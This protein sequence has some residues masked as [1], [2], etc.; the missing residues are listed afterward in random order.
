MGK[1]GA[2]G[3]PAPLGGVEPH[4]GLLKVP[5]ADQ[6]LYKIMTAE[7]LLQ[8]IDNRYL[9]FNRVDHYVDFPGADP[10]DGAQLPG[11]VSG[12]EAAR[13]AKVPVFSV[14]NYYDQARARTYACCFSLE[15]S[16]HIWTNYANGSLKGKV[17]IVFRY[18]PL[19]QLLNETFASD[20]SAL[21]YNSMQ[22]RQ[23]FSINYGL[24]E[25]VDWDVH[26]ANEKHLPNPICYSYLKSTAYE[27]EKEFRISLSAP[28]VGRFVLHDGGEMKFLPSLPVGFDFRK[29]LVTG[30]IVKILLAPD[31]DGAFIVSELGKRGVLPAP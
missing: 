24:V 30:A 29:A 4:A 2:A 28:G 5:P 27:K 14:A 1:H 10:Y 13:F 21:L 20:G 25:Y 16:D 8:S 3:I 6:L 15:N 19:R 23:I 9:H 31:G 26:R 11:D 17:G 7:N 22:C 18:D 12:N